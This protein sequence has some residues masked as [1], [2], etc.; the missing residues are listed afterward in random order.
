MVEGQ[1]T[2]REDG[3][4]TQQ[5]VQERRT[6]PMSVVPA[7]EHEYANCFTQPFRTHRIMINIRN[8]FQNNFICPFAFEKSHARVLSGEEEA[9]FAWTTVNYWMGT[10][11]TAMS[12][13]GAVC[14][15]VNSKSSNRPCCVLH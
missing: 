1:I 6:F 15:N 4:S 12:G 9:A 5:E 2:P 10:F 8:T 11:L 3:R 13:F 14:A 7:S